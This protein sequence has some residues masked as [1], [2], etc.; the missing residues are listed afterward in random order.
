LVG[1]MAE[2]LVGSKEKL[3]EL[4]LDLLWVVNLVENLVEKLVARKV[5]LLDSLTGQMKAYL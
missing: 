2:Q 4:L 3:S 5:E 1:V